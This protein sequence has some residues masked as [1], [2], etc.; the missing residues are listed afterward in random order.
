VYGEGQEEGKRKSRR[1]GTLPAFLC[2]AGTDEHE[3]FLTAV[4]A[5]KP[6]L[7]GKRLWIPRVAIISAVVLIFLAFGAAFHYRTRP[8]RELSVEEMV[9]LRAFIQT[10]TTAP[11][12]S[13]NRNRNG[14]FQVLAQDGLYQIE[15]K[16]QQWS[17]IR[18]ELM[19][20][21]FVK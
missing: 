4:F 8:P 18:H 10:K 21:C 3:R 7:D 20:V 5:G 1:G 11:I 19:I 6:T 15:R 13:M 14:S 16:G 2:F 9:D 12:L 17:I